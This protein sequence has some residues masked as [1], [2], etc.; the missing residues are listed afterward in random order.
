MK[1][2]LQTPMIID[3]LRRCS[4]SSWAQ[5]HRAGRNTLMFLIVANLAVYIFQTFLLKTN[6]YQTEV[7]FFTLEIWTLLS[8]MTLPLCI[9]YRFAHIIKNINIVHLVT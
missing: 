4:N 1:V 8:H 2:S 9:F 6:I 5:E 3:G 7:A